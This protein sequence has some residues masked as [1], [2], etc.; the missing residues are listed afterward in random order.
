MRIFAFLL[1]LLMPLAF[2]SMDYSGFL[3][4]SNQDIRLKFDN[5]SFNFVSGVCWVTLLNPSN[6]VVTMASMTHVTQ[7]MFKYTWAVP[8]SPLGDWS[9][10][11]NCTDPSTGQNATNGGLILVTDVMATNYSRTIN[12]SVYNQSNIIQSNFSQVLSE[13]GSISNGVQKNSS[14]SINDLN[15]TIN[16]SSVDMSGV[17]GAIGSL[18]NG[19]QAN[20]TTISSSFAAGTNSLL[21]SLQGNSSM[22]NQSINSSNFSP[23]ILLNVTVNATG[24]NVTVDLS[25]VNARIDRL[26]NDMSNSFE[27]L[28]R[29]MREMLDTIKKSLKLWNLVNP[30]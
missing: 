19:I 21:T 14:K 8:S 15:S 18:G 2:A 28:K 30:F 27:D 4:G 3:A 29:L 6:T 10:L 26:S 13:T 16:S 17:L 22:L 23:T 24:A 1:L 5:A 20:Q 7:G 11:F 12:S 25:S 9:V